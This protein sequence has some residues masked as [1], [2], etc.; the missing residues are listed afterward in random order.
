MFLLSKILSLSARVTLIF[1]SCHKLLL[2]AQLKR[3]TIYQVEQIST[4]PES[5][6]SEA[7][8]CKFKIFFG[9][10]SLVCLQLAFP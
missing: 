4:A 9:L 3:Y 6:F 5:A 10:V 1:R 2:K 8:F 7:F